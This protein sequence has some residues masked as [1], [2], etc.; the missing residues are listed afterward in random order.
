[1][2]RGNGKAEA[3]KSKAKSGDLGKLFGDNAEGLR[4]LV[5]SVCQEVIEAEIGQYLGAGPW[6]RTESRNGWRNGY[7]DRTIKTRI[8]ELHFQVPQS[9]DGKFAPEIFERYQRSEKALRLTLMEMVLQGVS[10]RKVEKV[11]EMLCGTQFSASLVSHLCKQMDGAIETFRHRPLTKAYPYLII[12]ARYEKVR[13]AGQIVDQA[14]LIIVGVNEDGYREVLGVE[15]ADLESE[16]TW[17]DIFCQLKDRGLQGVKLLV[18]DDHRGLYKA[19]TR[20]FTGCVWQRCRVHFIR[21]ICGY[22][23]RWARKQLIAKLHQIWEQPD[24]EPFQ[25]VAHATLD[26]Y[27]ERWP[28]VVALMENNLI[29]TMQVMHL[30][31]E[32]RKRLA[33]TNAIERVNQTIK[34]RTRVVRIFPNRESCIRLITA[35]LMELHEEWITGHRYFKFLEAEEAQPETAAA[36]EKEVAAVTA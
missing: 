14:I 17:G 5:E 21:N 22:V 2:A 9:R 6:E 12:D 25:E 13:V 18:S 11:T 15:I 27:R 1:M 29:D 24:I 35:I 36:T 8:G 34:A 7:K 4:S 30:P 23:P 32:H 10:T 28:K 31:E 26:E 16:S 33:T 19:L 3:G 20:Y